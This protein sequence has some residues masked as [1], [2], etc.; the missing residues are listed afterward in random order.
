MKKF[1]L[2]T[3]ALISLSA[4]SAAMAGGSHVAA[5]VAPANTG[6]LTVMVGGSLIFQSAFINKDENSDLDN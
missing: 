3:T 5:A 4:A 6:G 1:L 2:G